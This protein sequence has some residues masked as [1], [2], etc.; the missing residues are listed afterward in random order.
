M[1]HVHIF[2][3]RQ[4]TVLLSFSPMSPW[5]VALFSLLGM[6]AAASA[7]YTLTPPPRAVASPP[8]N[9]PAPVDEPIG[10]V[11]T[12]SSAPPPLAVAELLNSPPVPSPSTSSPAPVKKKPFPIAPDPAPEY[13]TPPPAQQ[14]QAAAPAAVPP[15]LLVATSSATCNFSIDGQVVSTGTLLRIS[16]PPGNH[17]VTCANPASTTPQTSNVFIT[18]DK[19]EVLVFR[20]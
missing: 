12:P 20:F 1:G 7:V 10:P 13:A 14:Q 6:T 15:G 9:E 11:P 2:V 8:P 4:P 18:S 5:R 19:A 17:S 16:L 3:T